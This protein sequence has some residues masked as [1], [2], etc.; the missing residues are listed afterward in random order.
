MLYSSNKSL[1]A[2]LAGL[3]I[4]FSL[5]MAPLM[6]GTVYST[7]SLPIILLNIPACS[8]ATGGSPSLYC[9]ALHFF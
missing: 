8:S 6:R 4:I 3:Y 9:S 1:G 7:T 5:P 2:L